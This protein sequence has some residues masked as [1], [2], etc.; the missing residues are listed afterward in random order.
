MGWMML[1][2]LAVAVIVFA[3]AVL[4]ALLFAEPARLAAGL[5]L[6]GPI[7][8]G[9]AGALLALVGRGAAGGIVMVAALGWYGMLRKRGRPS[10]P[11]RMPSFRTAAIEME[12][13]RDSGDLRGLVLAGSF[14]GKRLDELRL[15]ELIRLD[16]EL[17]SD[18]ESRALLET[19]LDGRF[20][21]WRTSRNAHVD[22]RE[23]GAHGAGAM[24]KQE[25]Y[26]VLGL[27]AGAS[28]A[29]IRKAH[30]GLLKRVNPEVGGTS[31]LAARINEA[32]DILLSDHG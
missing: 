19:Y 22:T 3:C 24:T 13:D 16:A 28:A 10:K 5:R 11:R 18:A 30:R 14:E 27:E 6:A 26:Q 25:A 21:I 31:V 4:Y 29:D 17:A 32:K 15:R 9:L 12:L 8:L 2:L 20:A 7:V 23:R 1:V